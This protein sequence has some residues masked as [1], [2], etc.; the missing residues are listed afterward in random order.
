MIAPAHQTRPVLILSWDHSLVGEVRAQS[1]GIPR[2]YLPASAEE[3]FELVAHPTAP[4]PRLV[5]I[6]QG[7]QGIELTRRLVAQC[8]GRP[9]PILVLQDDATKAETKTARDAGADVVL[10]KPLSRGELRAAL[11]RLLGH[12]PSGIRPVVRPDAEDAQ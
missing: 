6:D 4:T 11:V 8:P 7:H 1:H 2:V 3:T 10:S 5:I 9:M 12:E